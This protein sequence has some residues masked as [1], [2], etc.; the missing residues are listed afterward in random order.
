M[1][2]EIKIGIT[3]ISATIYILAALM[4]L[5]LDK[6][7]S[8]RHDMNRLVP[9][10]MSMFLWIAGG[11]MWFGGL[12]SLPVNTTLED[13]LGGMAFMGLFAF[14]PSCWGI[15]GIIGTIFERCDIAIYSPSY[16]SNVDYNKTWD[17]IIG[18][19]VDNS[20]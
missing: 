7:G 1:E 17:D 10:T 14:F 6:M 20:Y 3:I 12:Y 4:P 16:A 8:I 5:S 15:H 18:R 9:I 19:E 2:L 13:V 11:F